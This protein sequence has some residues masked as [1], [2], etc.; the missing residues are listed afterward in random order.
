MT[1]PNG[2]FYNNPPG[3]SNL[4]PW[5]AGVDGETLALQV[6]WRAY[7]A[8][9]ARLQSTKD[10]AGKKGSTHHKGIDQTQLGKYLVRV[11]PTGTRIG[12]KGPYYAFAIECEGIVILIQAR[13]APNGECPNVLV[14]IG[15]MVCLERGDQGA[16]ELAYDIIR[17]MGGEIEHVALSRNDFCV[18]MPGV[19]MDEFV[20][21]TKDGRFVTR[22]KCYSKIEF[23]GGTLQFGRPPLVLQIYDKRAEVLA[24]QNPRQRA[25]MLDR[26]WGGS[27]MPA[28]AVRVEFRIWREKLREF[29]IDTPEDFYR[30]RRILVDYLCRDRFRFI[31]GPVDRANTTRAATLPL[32]AQVREAF[33][34][35]AGQ[36]NGEILVPLPRGPV[37]VDHLLKQS[38]GVTKAIGREQGKEVVGYDAHCDLVLKGALV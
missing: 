24:K 4:C 29:G 38:Y 37:N 28:Q 1:F 15:G 8:L 13:C 23:Y 7:P 10:S 26:R 3:N 11:S 34:A 32:W 21:A 2:N 18:D 16:L 22:G 5:R 12:S 27:V 33:A 17:Q 35:W 14:T 30:K 19:G 6:S 9:H 36:P 20:E 25:L 31:A